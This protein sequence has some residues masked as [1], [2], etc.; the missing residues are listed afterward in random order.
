MSDVH[1]VCIPLSLAT[2]PAATSTIFGFWAPSSE[3]GGGITITKC[4]FASN[5]A[6]GLASAP[7]YTLVTTDSA[8]LINGTITSALASAAFAAGTPRVG[9]ISSAFV[10][11]GYGVAVKYA[12]TLASNTLGWIITAQVQY[13]MG[14]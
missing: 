14:R 12:Q 11:A 7:Y 1:N 6:I 5:T 3:V 4:T 8:G 13:V 2:A 9:T 10:E